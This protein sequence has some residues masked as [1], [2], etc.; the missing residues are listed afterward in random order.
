MDQD[1]LSK[2]S[3]RTYIHSSSF[4]MALLFTV[5]CGVALGILGYFTF[6]FNKD[7]FIESTEAVIE[8]ELKYAALLNSS[9]KITSFLEEEGRVFLL[10]DDNDIKV[11][12][13]LD[14]FPADINRLSEGTILFDVGKKNIAAKIADRGVLAP[15]V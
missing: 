8:S 6:Y 4:Q 7:T 2:T 9:D 5:L 14:K 10:V 3:A 1:T 13:N 11:A 15:A 12:G